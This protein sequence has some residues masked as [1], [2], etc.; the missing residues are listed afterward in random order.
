MV[1]V[2]AYESCTPKRSLMMASMPISVSVECSGF[3]FLLPRFCLVTPP[4]DVKVY[5]SYWSLKLGRPPA[6]PREARSLNSLSV[7]FHGHHPSSL[8]RQAPLTR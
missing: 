3:R 4:A 7:C 6:V 5:V 8:T 1:M 2:L